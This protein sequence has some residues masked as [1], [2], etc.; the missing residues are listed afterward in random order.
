MSQVHLELLMTLTATTNA[1]DLDA[2]MELFDI[3][4]FYNSSFGT[5]IDGTAY[6]GKAAVRAA[7]A[8]GFASCPDGRYD[9]VSYFVAG[10]HG[11]LRWTFRGTSAVT[12][13]QEL[14]RGCDLFEFAHD[15]IAVKDAFRKERIPT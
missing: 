15:K 13:E 7:F 10:E 14:V 3:D 5:E 2:V 12:G 4:C 11:A 9:D 1:H 8:A 6:R